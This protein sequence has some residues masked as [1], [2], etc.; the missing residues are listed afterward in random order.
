MAQTIKIKRSNSAENP[1]NLKAGELAYIHSSD[2]AGKLYIGRPGTGDANTGIASSI[3]IIGGLLDHDKLNGIEANADVT[4][5]TNVTAA[6][7]LMESEVANLAQV[8]AF[9]SSA[10]LTAE[11]ND[12]STTVT[13]ANV[14]DANITESS[15]TQYLTA[16][17]VTSP[18][19]GGTGISVAIDGTITND[20]PDQT[21]ALTGA[22][23]TSVTGTYPN[24]TITSSNT[25]TDY[26]KRIG[27]DPLNTS[28]P[29]LTTSLT[30]GE[31][32][33]LYRAS[34]AGITGLAP[35]GSWSSNR[36]EV[37][38]LFNINGTGNPDQ[39]SGWTSAD[40]YGILSFVGSN[41]STAEAN[42]FQTLINTSP[43]VTQTTIVADILDGDYDH[44]ID[45]KVGINVNYATEALDV[46]GNIAVSGTVDGVDIATL[47]ANAITAHQDISGKADLSGSTFTGDVSV[48]GNADLDGTVT[49]G[50]A[51]VVGTGSVGSPEFPA[52]D[53]TVKADLIVD[54]NLTVSG[55]TTTINTE[56]IE[57]ADN[58]IELNSN[59]TGYAGLGSSALDAGLLVNRGTGNDADG[60]PIY[61]SSLK[62]SEVGGEWGVTTAGYTYRSLLHVGN[63]EDKIT[64]L[65][66]GTFS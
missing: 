48:N 65:D 26:V 63:F 27:H 2:T 11:T 38:I 33:D 31:L 28:S 35:L 21:V 20:S 64:E 10:Y 15:V 16:A 54:G 59:V 42:N 7:A 34:L 58:I 55:T 60:N 41:Y 24:F 40:S 18:L 43:Y 29:L 53:T 3:D 19:T 50:S 39:T 9:D 61:T 22:G 51:A 23:G 4:D 32:A 14:P 45:D 30:I 5:T 44:L 17:N 8:K 49:L 12:L 25:L 1:T 36:K 6:G 47:G 57:L 37:Q 52:K 66:G 56:T 62:W 13:W 46:G